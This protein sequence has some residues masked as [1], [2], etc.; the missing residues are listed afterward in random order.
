MTSLRRNS[1]VTIPFT[2]KLAPFHIAVRSMTVRIDRLTVK[3]L[4]RFTRTFTINR[5]LAGGAHVVTVSV[6]THTRRTITSAVLP[7][8]VAQNGE[9]PTPTP[10]TGSQPDLGSNPDMHGFRSFPSDNPW[11][12]PVDTA[13][14]E[15]ARSTPYYLYASASLHPDFGGNGTWGIPVNVVDNTCPTYTVPFD[16]ADESDPGPYPIAPWMQVEGGW[17]TADDGQD[18]HLLVLNRDTGKL[19]EIYNIRNPAPGVYTGYSG[20]IFDTRSNALRP[21]YW[22]SSDAAGLPIFPALVKFDEVAAGRIDHALRFTL[23]H[24]YN[25]FVAPAR[26]AA[27][28]SDPQLS[29]MGM[30]VRLK[31]SVDT[32][33][34]GPQSKVIAQAMK[35]YGMFLADNGSNWFFQ[36][37]NDPRWDD[38]DLNTLKTLHGS[39]FEVVEMG[40][41]TAQE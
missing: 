3:S 39:D 5:T 34:L 23:Q 15:P 6:L 18:H 35:T 13:P 37:T 29:P 28:Y 20:A 16:I 22:T 38:D 33:H 19:Y 10:S 21:L 8:I 12:R 24:T 2:L 11:N 36:G 40:S 27:G 31:A 26:H 14:L 32:S 25:G 1:T 4:K 41:V 7:L 17:V 30:R 9:T